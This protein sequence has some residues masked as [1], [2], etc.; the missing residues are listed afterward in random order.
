MEKKG[1]SKIVLAWWWRPIL[2]L[3]RNK[4]EKPVNSY[5]FSP[6]LNS[7]CSRPSLRPGSFSSH[8]EER[9]VVSDR[10]RERAPPKPTQCPSHHM[11]ITCAMAA[12]PEA[13]MTVKTML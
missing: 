9:E 12:S 1:V 2:K 8:P 13:V 7:F 10:A 4:R 5:L 3:K 11:A 6:K